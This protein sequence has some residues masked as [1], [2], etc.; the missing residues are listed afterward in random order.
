MWT[1]SERPSRDK[2]FDLEIGHV[3]RVASGTEFII[4]CFRSHFDTVSPDIPSF[5]KDTPV[6]EFLEQGR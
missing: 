2:S 5:V 3:V 6:G 4:V 1:S